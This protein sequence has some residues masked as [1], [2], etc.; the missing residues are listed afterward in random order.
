MTSLR[1]RPTHWAATCV[2]VTRNGHCT[3]ENCAFACETDKESKILRSVT[4]PTVQIFSNNATIANKCYSIVSAK[5]AITIQTF[6]MTFT[7]KV[8]TIYLENCW[9]SIHIIVLVRAM[10]FNIHSFKSCLERTATL[11]KLKKEETQF[12]NGQIVV[13]FS[14]YVNS[15]SIF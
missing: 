11:S 5:T 10:H 3:C 15:F 13:N 12:F 14:R 9:Q 6:R 4:T 1:K 2:S 7:R 8:C